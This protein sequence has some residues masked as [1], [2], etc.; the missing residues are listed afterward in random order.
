M[1]IPDDA[2][3][4]QWVEAA[5]ANADRVRSHAGGLVAFLAFGRDREAQFAGTGFVIGQHDLGAIVLTAKHVLTEGVVNVQTPHLLHAP[6]AL[7]QF[8]ERAS[9]R[10]RPTTFIC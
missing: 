2:L 7:T 1:T 10:L 4:R 3:R 8:V 9:P 5:P 6:S